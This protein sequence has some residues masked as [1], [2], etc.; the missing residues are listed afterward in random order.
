MTWFG[1][2]VYAVKQNNRLGIWIKILSEIYN[3]FLF[4][5]VL[6][7]QTKI[8]TELNAGVESNRYNLK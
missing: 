6:L 8:I 4:R 3:Y 2:V 7:V 5:A 1:W